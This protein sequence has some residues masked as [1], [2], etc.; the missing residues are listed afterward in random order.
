M[1]ANLVP[2]AVISVDSKM[3][4]AI[5]AEPINIGIEAPGRSVMTTRGALYS[6]CLFGEWNKALVLRSSSLF[7]GERLD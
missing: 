2:T 1:P 7:V 4:A 3:A 5:R 6:C